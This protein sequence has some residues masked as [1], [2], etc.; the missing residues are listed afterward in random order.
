MTQ[1]SILDLPP[2]SV[3]VYRKASVPPRY[4][5]FGGTVLPNSF[6]LNIKK[7]HRKHRNDG[8]KLPTIVLKGCG[9]QMFKMMFYYDIF[10]E[11]NA[12]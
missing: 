1:A 3:F 8:F 4:I 5:L 12:D 11:K 6:S 9:C 7:T 2:Y 10:F